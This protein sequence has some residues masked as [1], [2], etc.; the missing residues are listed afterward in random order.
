MIKK[1]AS[2][3]LVFIFII[4]FAYSAEKISPIKV[5]APIQLQIPATG[6]VKLTNDQHSLTG[7]WSFNEDFQ[8][9]FPASRW[10][11]LASGN[12]YTWGKTFNHPHNGNAAGWC[13]ETNLFGGTDLDAGIDNYAGNMRAWMIAGPFEIMPH[14]KWGR[15]EFYH[16]THIINP[17]YFFV[18]FSV[19]GFWFLGK[20]LGNTS[21]Y[22]K[23]VMNVDDYLG[24]FNSYNHVWIG[25]LFDSN[26]QATAPGVWLDDIK[27][28]FHYYDPTVAMFEAMPLAGKAP[29]EVQ[30]Y[31]TSNGTP[32]HF[33]WDYGDGTVEELAEARPHWTNPYHVYTKPGLYDVSLKAWV[34]DVEDMLTIPDLIYVDSD[35]EYIPL[36][37]L[38]GG[39]SWP[40]EWWDNAIDHDVYGANCKVA[41]LPDQ[42]VAMFQMNG[43]WNVSKIR[44]MVDTAEPHNCQ[45]NFAKKVQ[46]TLSEDAVIGDA[47]DVTILVDCPRLNGEWNEVDFAAAKAEYAQ[48]DIVEARGGRYHELVEIQLM[49][50]ETTL[51]KKMPDSAVAADLPTTYDLAQ[52]YPNPFNPETRICFQLPENAPVELS[53]YN[54]QG[55]LIRTLINDQLAAGYHTVHW[56][57]TN[58]QGQP[59]SGGVYIYKLRV[60]GAS[61]TTI[62]TRK[63]LLLK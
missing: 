20:Y 24:P 9:A 52:N 17:D 31:N 45:T 54:V 6:S 30:F 36:S 32:N 25:F 2:L 14:I 5:K 58:E 33:I 19:D 34:N 47:G 21:G 18:G 37:V 40:G 43:L 7:M 60:T 50:K 28:R 48:V 23:E 39:D 16:D 61:Q 55:Q 56:N 49:G 13:A 62:F 1:A 12:G 26:C 41:A 59:V 35:L 63:M 38:S 4:S 53:L 57:A 42:S 11:L 46:V 15:L 29:L 51:A 22:Q 8:G 10:Q 44:I 3:T 27:L